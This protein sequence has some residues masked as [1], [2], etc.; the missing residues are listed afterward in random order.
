MGCEVTSGAKA[1]YLHEMINRHLIFCPEPGGKECKQELKANCYS[2]GCAE[3]EK[4]NDKYQR[5]DYKKKKN[6]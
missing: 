5:K 3:K 4:E 2:T 6:K 1:P